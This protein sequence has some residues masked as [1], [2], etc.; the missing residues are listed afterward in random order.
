MDAVVRAEVRALADL[1][2]N[3]QAHRRCVERSADAAEAWR[4]VQVCKRRLVRTHEA[5][6]RYAAA[7]RDRRPDCLR[8][9]VVYNLPM[10]SRGIL[11]LR[12]VA[13]RLRAAEQ[14]GS[15][16]EYT[17]RCVLPPMLAGCL[18]TV[19]NVPVREHAV[20][21]LLVRWILN[22][23]PSATETAQAATQF[24]VPHRSEQ[25]VRFVQRVQ[26]RRLQLLRH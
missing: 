4:R 20:V 26:S 6:E 17:A 15:G 9:F 14:T 22:A 13:Q 12:D 5:R 7:Q 23:R 11:T 16:A 25:L 10:S 2:E 3:E 8:H 18:A 21:S 19:Q 1:R 24:G